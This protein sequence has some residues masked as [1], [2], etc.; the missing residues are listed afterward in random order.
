MEKKR[1]SFARRITS[2]ILVWSIIIGI[3]LSYVILHFESK[4]IRGLYTDI[5]YNK[6]LV[7][8]EY[9]KR[10]ISDVY[11]AVTNNIY[12]IEQ[13]LDKPDIHKETMARIV[14]SGTRIRSC[15]I[16]FVEDFYPRKGHSF[17]P[18]AWRNATTPDII[19]QEDLGDGATD[20]LNSE[21][22]QECVESDSARWSDPFLRSH[23]SNTPKTAYIAPVHDKN[24]R[25]VALIG[26]DISLDW[27]TGKLD[28]TDSTI[29]KSTMFPLST[30]EIKTKSYLINHDGRFITHPDVKRIMN[31]NFFHQLKS[32]DG[33]DITELINKMKTGKDSSDKGYEILMVNGEKCHVFYTPIRY[34]KWLL[35]Y[36]VPCHD[37]NI[38]VYLNSIPLLLILIL[39]IVLIVLVVHH[40]IK[41]GLE[42]MKQ[43]IQ[44]TDN[45][46]K[47][48]FN[49]PVPGL[50][51]PDEMSQLCDS[52]E[53]MKYSLSNYADDKK[54]AKPSSE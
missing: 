40:F 23:N 28:E 54:R 31:D 47:G 42:P 48:N 37:T 17:C 44:V 12:Y 5:Y 24:G 38:M 13:T 21:W 15:G 3:A 46:A 4:V 36:V 2:K 50:K 34:T 32:C 8:M 22:F 25:V 26:A 16:S 52:I 51:Y 18:F 45:I 1:K 11:V 30:F 49:T 9:T 41:E 14:H 29:I 10:V 20:Y 6:M 43:L 7:T 53:E 35:V 19:Y 33:S 27:L 39:I